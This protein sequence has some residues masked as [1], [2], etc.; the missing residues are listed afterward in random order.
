MNT[1]T[2]LSYVHLANGGNS[3][4]SNG[5]LEVRDRYGDVSL[6]HILVTGTNTNALRVSYM[7]GQSN[8]SVNVH[9]HHFKAPGPVYSGAEFNYNDY[10]N[11]H[12]SDLQIHNALYDGMRI[13]YND[14]SVMQFKNL[15]IKDG[16][17]EAM[18]IYNNQNATQVKVELS[19]FVNNNQRY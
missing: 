5:A 6:N 15:D 10:L 1:F 11:L 8:D 14:Y 7:K 9:V 3:T 4:W 16:E 17:E 2:T 13:E 18:R 12:V 19:N